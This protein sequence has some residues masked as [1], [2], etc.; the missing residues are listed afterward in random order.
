MGGDLVMTVYEYAQIRRTVIEHACE[1]RHRVSHFAVKLAMRKGETMTPEQRA[2]IGAANRGNSY[3]AGNLGMKRTP[4]A[5]AR[6]SAA[7]RAGTEVRGPLSYGAVHKRLA[8]DRGTPALCE[9]CGTT[10]ARKFEWAYAGEGH[11]LG[12]WSTNLD[13]Y[14]RLCTKCHVIFDGHPLP[15][16]GRR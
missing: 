13:D 5:R 6:M 12:E 2:K 9:H 1:N 4:E 11:E 7:R 3:G 16:G 14:I 10:T 8:K 15:P